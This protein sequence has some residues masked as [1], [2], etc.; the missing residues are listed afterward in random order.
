MHRIF[1]ENK[2]C[3]NKKCEVCSFEELSSPS[4]VEELWNYD[5]VD[6][7]VVFVP[8]LTKKFNGYI[9]NSRWWFPNANY[10]LPINSSRRGSRVEPNFLS[11]NMTLLC[12]EVD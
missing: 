8:S 1:P 9:S 11:R 10:P 7:N 3:R 4:L 6:R 5:N 2:L 12:T